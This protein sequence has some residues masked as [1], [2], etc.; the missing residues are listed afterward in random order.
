MSE[1]TEARAHRPGQSM[2]WGS[3]KK[4]YMNVRV[5]EVATVAMEKKT[6]AEKARADEF[7][8]KVKDGD[9]A[10]L[11]HELSSSASVEQSRTL[12]N[13]KSHGISVLMLASA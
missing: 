11:Q 10:W 8:K 5:A 1:T 2:A 6:A 3:L 7:I 13:L 4:A 12:A 9:V